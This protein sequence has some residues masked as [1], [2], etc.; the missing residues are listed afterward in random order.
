MAQ[1][2][3][4]RHLGLHCWKRI[5]T[6]VLVHLHLPTSNWK[7]LEAEDFRQP[8]LHGQTQNG[9]DVDLGHMRQSTHR[10]SDPPDTFHHRAK[11]DECSI[12]VPFGGIG[13]LHLQSRVSHTGLVCEDNS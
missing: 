8:A 1:A 3:T 2:S 9:R 10:C 5:D 13:G 4:L 6:M 12:E 7:H 11:D